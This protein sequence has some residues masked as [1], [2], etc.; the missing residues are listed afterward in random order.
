MTIENE[1]IPAPKQASGVANQRPSKESST[2]ETIVGVRAAGGNGTSSKV[3]RADAL[4]RESIEAIA[5]KYAGAY[6][7]GLLFQDADSF[8]RFSDDLI[9]AA[10]PSS[11]PAAAPFDTCACGY[12]IE[13]SCNVLDPTCRRNA[14]PSPA[15]ERAETF[16]AW[17]K[18]QQ[19][20]NPMFDER[21][22]R[23]GWNA[24]TFGEKHGLTIRFRD[25]G[26]KMRPG[27]SVSEEFESL[28]SDLMAAW[29]ARASAN[30]TGAE[31]VR[32]WETDDGRVI[33]DEQKQQALRDGGASASS[34]RP[35]SISLGRIGAVPAMAAEAVAIP[36]GW[37]KL[38]ESARS[39]RSLYHNTHC[40]PEG[41]RLSVEALAD[42]AA[43]LLAAPQPAQ[44]DA[45]QTDDE[46]WNQALRERDIY[47]EY[48]D[49]LASAIANHL[50]I[51]IGEHS[52]FNNP[53]LK[54]LEAIKNARQADARVGLTD[55]HI[56][57]TFEGEIKNDP[58]A[59]TRPDES[60]YQI[61]AKE[62]VRAARALLAAHPGQPEPRAEV[63]PTMRAYP[64][65]L[66]ADLRHVLGF[67]NFRCGPYAHLMRAAGADIKAKAEDEQAYVLHYLV[68]MVLDHGAR[69]ADVAGD[70][71]EAMRD[72]VSVAAA[73]GAHANG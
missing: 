6:F 38:A 25:L 33:S 28:V 17:W 14:A 42:E 19:E 71:L 36:A 30:E 11:Q 66:T 58:D 61:T 49:E 29:Q 18:R 62:L 51:E 21:S 70:E 39:L 16:E 60:V 3:G 37:L 43:K 64:D 44:A 24:A 47:E 46:W 9:L 12:S 67:P 59:Y 31:G 10:F 34:V 7:S 45:R 22:A 55:E 35:F 15:D 48:A 20:V 53:W 13:S 52:N 27:R 54:A 2:A 1:K 65:E 73:G 5:R 41:F 26:Y 50:H 57:E 56:I 23:V 40:N 69:W 32:A 4:T 68:K 72:K 8:A 63:V